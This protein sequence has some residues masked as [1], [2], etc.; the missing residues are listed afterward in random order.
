M[1]RFAMA[2][3]AAQQ[4][5]LSP[6]CGRRRYLVYNRIPML[7]PGFAVRCRRGR[8]RWLCDAV[9]TQGSIQQLFTQIDALHVLTS[10]AGFEALLRGLEST[11]GA[12]RFMRQDSPMTANVTIAGSGSSHWTSWCMPP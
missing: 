6:R 1:P 10:L 2:P 4:Q 8:C 11:A 9:L 12:F 7:W 3:G 5:R